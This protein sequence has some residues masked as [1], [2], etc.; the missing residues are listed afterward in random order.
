M[1]FFQLVLLAGYAY[2]HVLI[3]LLEAEGADRRCTP[4]CCGELRAAADSAVASW[5]PPKAGDPTLR[6]LMLLAATIG[7][8]YFLLSST[9]PLLQAWYVR[10]S[11]SGMPYRLFALSN[12]GSMLALLSFPFLVEPRLTSRQQAFTWSGAY[13]LFA[14]ALRV[15][16]VDQP[17]HGEERRSGAS[18]EEAAAW[19][20]VR[21]LAQLILWVAL[22]ACA[23]T[24]LVAVTNHMSQNVAP[25]PLLWVVPLAIYLLTFILAFESDRIYKRWIFLPLLAPALGGM[26]YMIWA[27]SGNLHIKWLIPGFALGLFLCCMMCH[28]ELARRKPGAAISDAVL[29]DGFA[30]RRAGRDFRRADRAARI[31]QSI[32][33]C[34]SAW[35]FARCWP[36]SCCGTCELPKIGRLAAAPVLVIARR[37]PGRIPGPRTSMRRPRAIV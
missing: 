20:G 13:V 36:P 34:R 32:S 26:A 28:G 4:A 14:A 9:S 1:L 11:G 25:I 21:A 31:S 27:D 35:W 2:A 33:N 17:R 22:A 16:G 5:K 7:L 6:I 30:R 29:S 23:S 19:P 37:S 24:L 15:R 8:P 3:R 12:F 10:R 18:V